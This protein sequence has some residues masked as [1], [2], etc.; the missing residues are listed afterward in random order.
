VA[1]VIKTASLDKFGLTSDH[2]VDVEDPAHWIPE[3]DRRVCKGERKERAS[4]KQ[5]P[6]LRACREGLERLAKPR[7]ERQ[8]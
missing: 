2:G 7:E 6:N 1:G 5:N 8:K 3:A 4:G